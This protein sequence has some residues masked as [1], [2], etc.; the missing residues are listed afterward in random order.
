MKKKEKINYH[1]HYHKSEVDLEW[2]MRENAT[3]AFES[4]L[5]HG[6]LE[7][8]GVE[9]KKWRGSAVSCCCKAPPT[10]C[11][12]QSPCGGVDVFQI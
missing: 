1:Y 2:R 10:H 6:F 9:G 5:Q 11:P 7:P 8:S 3:D 4:T 12:I